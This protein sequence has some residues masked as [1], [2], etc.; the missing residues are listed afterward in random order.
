M[1]ALGPFLRHR[2]NT[3]RFSS[4]VYTSGGHMRSRSTAVSVQFA[5][6]FAVLVAAV[7]SACV[8]AADSAP[9]DAADRTV[10]RVLAQTITRSTRA[11]STTAS[12]IVN[13]NTTVDVAFQVPG[14]V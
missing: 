9:S 3:V 1:S 11:W 10:V 12:G 13:A 8:R 6:A 4:F 7:A 14:K 5:Q 2:I